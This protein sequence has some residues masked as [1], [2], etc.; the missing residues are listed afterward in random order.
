MKVMSSN[1]LFLSCR[2]YNDTVRR[3]ADPNMTYSS[4]IKMTDLNAHLLAFK[5]VFFFFFVFTSKLCEPANLI[6]MI[7]KGPAN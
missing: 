7:H 5:C 3:A 6:S 1:S 4:M 2:T